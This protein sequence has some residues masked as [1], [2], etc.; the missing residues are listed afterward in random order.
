[1]HPHAWLESRLTMLWGILPRNLHALFNAWPVPLLTILTSKGPTSLENL[2]PCFH[3]EPQKGLQAKEAV[4][5][6]QRLIIPRLTILLEDRPSKM[7]FCSSTD[8]LSRARMPCR[9]RTGI[10]YLLHSFLPWT[11]LALIWGELCCPLPCL[12]SQD[13]QCLKEPGW[14]Y[15]SPLL[16]S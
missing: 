11:V 7:W 12:D 2:C 9:A 13:L 1:M 4:P 15:C 10:L 16:P 8:D 14:G 5:P 6:L 3:R